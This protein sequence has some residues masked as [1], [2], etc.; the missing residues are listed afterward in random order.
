MKSEDVSTD[1]KNLTYSFN[2]LI[3][4]PHAGRNFFLGIGKD[5]TMKIFFGVGRSYFIGK[6]QAFSAEDRWSKY[7]IAKSHER[8]KRYEDRIQGVTA[9][10]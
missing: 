4:Q 3:D 5:Q 8:T 7:I 2:D 1:K 6:I 9:S 10:I